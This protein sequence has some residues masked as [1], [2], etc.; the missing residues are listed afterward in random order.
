MSGSVPSPVVSKRLWLQRLGAFL[1]QNITPILWVLIGLVAVPLALKYWY[2]TQ[3]ILGLASGSGGIDLGFYYRWSREWFQGVNVYLAHDLPQG[4][5]PASMVLF[6]PLV[7]W[8]DMDTARWVWAVTTLLSFLLVVWLGIR[9]VGSDSIAE[10]IGL[11]FLLLLVNGTSVTY[12]NGQS[13]LHVLALVLA[14]ILLLHT[15]PPSVATDLL[16]AALF[17]A[18]LVKPNLTLPFV[19]L[20]LFFPKSIRLGPLLLVA[21]MYLALSLYAAQVV[22]TPLPDL[23]RQFLDNRLG[24]VGTSLD[25]NLQYGLSRMG[26]EGLLLPIPLLLLGLLGIWVYFHRSLEIWDLMA[27]TAL[28]MRVWGHHW[29]YDNVFLFIPE[30]ALIQRVKRERTFASP[31][32]WLLGLNV[33]VLLPPGNLGGQ[34]LTVQM[35]LAGLQATVWFGTCLYFLLVFSPTKGPKTSPAQR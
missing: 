17:T 20:L 33:L 25:P 22:Q 34:S 26:L 6:Y 23:L 13:S 5:P 30:I 10:K 12:G 16:G 28:V 11:A 32:V 24:Q 4:Y 2:E 31:A 7:G 35:V 18:A 29:I 8:G 9:A 19:W 14:A 21:V 27:V 1:R 15:R 3:R